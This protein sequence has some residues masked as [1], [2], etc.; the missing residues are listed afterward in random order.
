MHGL[1]DLPDHLEAT[2]E[3]LTDATVRVTDRISAALDSDLPQVNALCARLESYRGKMLRP[4]LATLSATAA[5]GEH[6]LVSSPDVDTL[7][8]TVEAI[9]LATLVHDDVLDEADTRRG[10]PTISSLTTNETAVI[11]GDYCIAAAYHLCS[12][13]HDRDIALAVARCCMDTCAGEIV[14]LSERGNLALTEDTYFRIITGKTAELIG[15]SCRL[16]ALLGSRDRAAA[17]ALHR[18]GIALGQAFQIQDD[19]LDLIGDEA[20]V[21]KTVGRDIAKGKLTLPMIHHL[22]ALDPASRASAE[23]LLRAAAGDTDEAHN[24]AHA[25]AAGLTRTRSVEHA[26]DTAIRLSRDAVASLE[27][28]PE[29]PARAMLTLMAEAAV[30]RDR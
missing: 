30:K 1:I 3:A 9:H 26:R 5:A 27:A 29:T 23:N 2:A 12:E 8:A 6:A 15:A 7:A 20:S 4:V 25:F 11:L 21:G 10:S 17:D 28:V 16:G 22:H 19:V 14:Q 24:A 18:F 13:L